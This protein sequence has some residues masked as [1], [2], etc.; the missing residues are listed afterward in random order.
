MKEFKF[1]VEVYIDGDKDRTMQKTLRVLSKHMQGAI[2]KV[3][4]ENDVASIIRIFE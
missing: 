2:R 4:Q 1:L 3:Y